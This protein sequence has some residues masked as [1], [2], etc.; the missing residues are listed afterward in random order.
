[1]MMYK[2]AGEYIELKNPINDARFINFQVAKPGT[3]DFIEIGDSEDT[4]HVS[5]MNLDQYLRI[6][7]LQAIFLPLI[8]KNKML[9]HGI[10]VKSY[11]R[12][13]IFIGASGSGKTSLGKILL[14]SVGEGITIIG[15]DR[16]I[17]GQKDNR[18]VVWN[19]PWSKNGIYNPDEMFNVYATILLFKSE[20]YRLNKIDYNT[21]EDYLIH[22]YPES[23]RAQVITIAEQLF[24][25]V[26]LWRLDNSLKD[27]S[28]NE[29]LKELEQ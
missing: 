6:K 28:A 13:Y 23:C 29:L 14:K 4:K 11:K 1:M 8:K 24:S 27:F 18:L 26:K 15:D 21:F 5:Q 9:L 19:T 3:F 2:I 7:S 12:T 10:G 22:Q 17:V 25:K 16:L 20:T